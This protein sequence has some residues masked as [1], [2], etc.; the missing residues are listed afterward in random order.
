MLLEGLENGH[1][2]YY[3]AD[4]YEN[5][6]GVFFCDHYEKEL[7]D[8]ILKK[9]LFMPNVLITPLQSFAT[10]EG[11][12]NIAATTF[13]NID[14][15]KK[16]QRSKNELTTQGSLTQAAA[17]LMKPQVYINYVNSAKPEIIFNRSW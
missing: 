2:G 14:C 7:Q 4:V 8:D 10:Q 12:T 16:N 11:L 9:L 13:Y 5:E 15:W 3:G 6:R 17:Y 1:I